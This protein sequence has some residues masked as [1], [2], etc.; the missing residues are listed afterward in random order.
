MKQKSREKKIDEIWASQDEA[1]NLMR[2]YDDIPHNY[3]EYSLFQVEGEFIDIIG[4]NHGIT[5][6]E[7]A[8][9]LGKTPSACSQIVR[10]L[11][12]KEMVV[13]VRDELNNRRL[14]SWARKYMKDI[15]YLR[16]NV[17]IIL[18]NAWRSSL[19]KH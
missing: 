4:E 8:E 18:R 9:L 5:M 17:R 13:Q 1:Y 3:G 10:K 2:A 19:K 11:R 16:K 7:I 14:L 12:K 6:T 15:N